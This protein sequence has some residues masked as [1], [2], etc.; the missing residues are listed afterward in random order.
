M[1]SMN[2]LKVGDIIVKLNNKLVSELRQDWLKY[3]A[4][5]NEKSKQAVI[6]LLLF[7]TNNDTIDILISRKN[8]MLNLKVKSLSIDELKPIIITERSSG[9]ILKRI[10]INIAYINLANL[11]KGDVDSIM[12]EATQYESIIFDLRGYSRNTMYQISEYLNP[13]KKCFTLIY[14]PDLDFPGVFRYTDMLEVG[15]D[16]INSNY[17]KGKVVVL[18]DINTQSHGEFACMAL[19]TAPD[20][21]I[22]GSKTSGADGNVSNFRLPGNITVRF[23]GIGIAY[24]NGIETQRIGIIPDIFIE[25]TIRGI[26][27]KKDDV[28]EKA[29]T[30]LRQRNSF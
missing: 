23:S 14:S 11:E 9:T 1:D 2:V 10:S 8:Q 15:P 16:S 29:I 24:P 17:Y 30:V 7:R 20:V 21:T 22:I 6:D 18:I 13:E 12:H 27:N 25:Q 5:S 3:F 19:Q 26:I 4:G 28:L